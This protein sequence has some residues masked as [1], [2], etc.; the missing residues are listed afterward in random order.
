MKVYIPFMERFREP[1]LN[2]TKTW[3]SRTK[4]Y[5]QMG[6]SFEAFGATFEIL[7]VEK[8]TLEEILNHWREEGLDSFSDALITWRKIHPIRKLDFLEQF[9][10]HIFKKEKP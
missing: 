9:W 1:L 2:G 10:T 8:K 5:G 6:D 3:T 7:T 4:R